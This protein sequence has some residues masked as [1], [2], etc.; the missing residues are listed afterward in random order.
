MSEIVIVTTAE[1]IEAIIERV[2]EQAM[3]ETVPDALR[4]ALAPK[5]MSRDQVQECYGLTPRQLTYL[6]SKRRVTYSQHGRRILYERASIEQY[7]AN[8]R[9]AARGG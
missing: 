4:E 9:V 3:L 8:G 2:V 6:R 5:W 1:Q 7:I